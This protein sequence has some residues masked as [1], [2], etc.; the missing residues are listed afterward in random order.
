MKRIIFGIIF[1]LVIAAICGSIIIAQDV[2]IYYPTPYD[3]PDDN[4]MKDDIHITNYYGSHPTSGGTT[5]SV[6]TDN[7]IGTGQPEEN[8]YNTAGIYDRIFGESSSEIPGDGFVRAYSKIKFVNAVPDINK[9]SVWFDDYLLTEALGYAHSTEAIEIQPGKVPFEINV[10]G[11]NII[12]TEINLEPGK[13]HIAFITGMYGGTVTTEWSNNVPEGVEMNVMLIT[14]DPL[15]DN[16][17]SGISF[18]NSAP[19]INLEPLSLRIGS[20]TD[21]LFSIFSNKGFRE[22]SLTQNVEPGAYFIDLVVSGT[23]TPITNPLG[24]K[25]KPGKK[26]YVIA[27]APIGFGRIKEREELSMN[28]DDLFIYSE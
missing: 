26:Y 23:E 10:F 4:V 16:T 27:F 9:M 11:Q 24:V 12:Q 28:T 21:T 20:N 8:D 15:T 5:T 14:E 18:F 25:L 13:E 1:I 7:G 3:Y 17:K 6:S 19:V 2:H 22:F